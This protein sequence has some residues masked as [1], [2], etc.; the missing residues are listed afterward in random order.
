MAWGCDSSM[1]L[2]YLKKYKY[3]GNILYNIWTAAYPQN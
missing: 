1:P 2:L 3:Y